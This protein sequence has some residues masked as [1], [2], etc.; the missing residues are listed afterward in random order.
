MG[1]QELGMTLQVNH[2]HIDLTRILLDFYLSI[3][4][5]LSRFA[6]LV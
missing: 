6:S 3:S 2:H 4:P 1:L 5:S